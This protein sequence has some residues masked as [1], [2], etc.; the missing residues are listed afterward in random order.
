M[1][2][3][4]TMIGALD[5]LVQ[6][7]GHLQFPVG[8]PAAAWHLRIVRDLHLRRRGPLHRLGV[9]RARRLFPQR[10][11]DRN[12]KDACKMMVGTLPLVD[13][14]RHFGGQRL[15]LVPAPLGQVQPRRH[16]VRRFDLLYLRQPREG[17]HGDKTMTTYTIEV[18][19]V[20]DD[21]LLHLDQRAQ[22]Q[23]RDRSACI[24]DLL[25]KAIKE[26]ELTEV[27]N[28]EIHQMR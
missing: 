8:G 9:D 20:P 27:I 23:G 19:D 7:T 6:P 11:A 16:P 10:C 25:Q 1:F 26:E 18:T 3:N 17:Y 4:G 14:G 22:Q 5:A 12:G 28:A 24:R 21:L 2:Q 15:A 13:H